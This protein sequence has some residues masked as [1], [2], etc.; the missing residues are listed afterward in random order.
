MWNLRLLKLKG[1][2]NQ[3]KHPLIHWREPGEWHVPSQDELSE[4]EIPSLDNLRAEAGSPAAAVPAGHGIDAPQPPKRR[5]GR[6]LLLVVV[7]VVFVAI[8]VVLA[9]AALNGLLDGIIPPGLLP[10]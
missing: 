1:L 7:F 6:L 2:S 9:L 10:N 4:Y 5:R 3:W 8:G